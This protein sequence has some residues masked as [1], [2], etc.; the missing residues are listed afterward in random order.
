[1]ST[2]ITDF[3]SLSTSEIAQLVRRSKAAHRQDAQNAAKVQF[4]QESSESQTLDQFAT[5]NNFDNDNWMAE[6][7]RRA[8]AESYDMLVR[9]CQPRKPHREVLEELA[10]QDSTLEELARRGDVEAADE[11]EDRRRAAITRQFL[12]STPAYY[13]SRHNSEQILEY[14][15]YN[16]DLPFTVENLQRAAQELLASGRLEQDPEQLTV[17]TNDELM[18]LKIK[19]ANASDMAVVARIAGEYATLRAP[20]KIRAKLRNGSLSVEHFSAQYPELI[21]EAA[22]WAFK[23]T[24]RDYQETQERYQRFNELIGDKFVTIHLLYELWEIIKREESPIRQSLYGNRNVSG[25]EQT[26]PTTDAEL[27]ALPPEEFEKLRVASIRL[28]AKNIRAT[29]QSTFCQ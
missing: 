14:M 23:E 26:E 21:S 25:S 13:C 16:G 4:V 10:N 28:A 20:K 2:E 5:D 1:M 17:L 12:D 19:A 15:E 7:A 27:E 3:D 6:K 8:E 29:G 11:L 22:Y 24:A 18:R 9:E